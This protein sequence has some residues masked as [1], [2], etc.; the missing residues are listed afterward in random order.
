MSIDTATTPEWR[1]VSVDNGGGDR[2]TAWDGFKVDRVALAATFDPPVAEQGDTVDFTI[3]ARGSDFLSGTPYIEFS[4][5]F[6]S[7]PDIVVDSVRDVDAES[8]WAD[9]PLQRCSTRRPRRPDQ[10]ER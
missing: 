9:D 5:L 10:R 6:G 1:N 7:N 2:T 8:L 3:Q 4:D